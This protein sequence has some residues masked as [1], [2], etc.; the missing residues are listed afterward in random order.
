MKPLTG[1]QQNCLRNGMIWRKWNTD[2]PR[3]PKPQASERRWWTPSGGQVGNHQEA[4]LRSRPV[5][6]EHTCLQ[7]WDP[8][9]MEIPVSLWWTVT[10]TAPTG[11]GQI[12]PP[13]PFPRGH[14]CKV[15]SYDDFSQ[16]STSRSRSAQTQ[17]LRQSQSSRTLQLLVNY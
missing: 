4:Q 12:S 6:A 8:K 13:T 5:P 2:W 1:Q 3:E 9:F 16:H 10:C 15:T 7:D 11:K 17:Q 14:P